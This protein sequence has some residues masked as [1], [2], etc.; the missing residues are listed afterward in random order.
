MLKPLAHVRG[1]RGQTDPGR[2]ATSKHSSEPLQYTDQPFQGKASNPRPTSILRPLA[3]TTTNPPQTRPRQNKGEAQEPWRANPRFV[4]PY[5]FRTWEDRGRRSVEITVE[6]FPRPLRD[7]RAEAR[8]LL[9]V[10]GQPAADW[11]EIPLRKN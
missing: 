4:G 10:A 3:N 5:L 1:S 7:D 9:E 2:W 6:Y 8:R 11:H